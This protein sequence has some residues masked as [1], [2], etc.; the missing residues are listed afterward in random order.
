MPNEFLVGARGDRVVI[1]APYPGLGTRMPPVTLDREQALELAA[2]LVCV[3]DPG[4]QRFE[5][6]LE[7]VAN[8]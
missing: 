7:L 1:M 2:W 8:S 3:A 4:G 5:Q 6:V